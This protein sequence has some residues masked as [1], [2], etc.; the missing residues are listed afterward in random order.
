[1]YDSRRPRGAR[2]ELELGLRRLRVALAHGLLEPHEFA[3]LERRAADL[4]V[5]GGA[6]LGVQPV[7]L[8]VEDVGRVVDP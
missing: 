8:V 3:A 6:K 7:D 5:R 1:V 2:D 4:S